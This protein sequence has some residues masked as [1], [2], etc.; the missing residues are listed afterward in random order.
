MIIRHD[1]FILKIKPK[2]IPKYEQIAKDVLSWYKSKPI[3]FKIRNY[4]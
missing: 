1:E 3:I 4:K 2:D